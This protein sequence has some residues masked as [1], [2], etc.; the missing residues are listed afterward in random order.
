M[1]RREARAVGAGFNGLT[2]PADVRE[3][4][5]SNPEPFLA[6]AKSDHH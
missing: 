2:L 5:P 1:H 3:A 4:G 6:S